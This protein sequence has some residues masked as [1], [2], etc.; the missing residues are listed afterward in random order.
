MMDVSH[1]DMR[2]ISLVWGFCLYS[3]VQ[4]Y[5]FFSGACV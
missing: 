2:E 1:G 3:S 5:N 4:E